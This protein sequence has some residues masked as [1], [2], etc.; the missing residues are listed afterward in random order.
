MKRSGFFKKRRLVELSVA[1]LIVCAVAVYFRHQTPV[2]Q[3]EPELSET[4]VAFT[5][6][7]MENAVE[8]MRRPFDPQHFQES[9]LKGQ[10]FACDRLLKEK[11]DDVNLLYERGGVHYQMGNVEAAVDDLSRI[12]E[13]QPD[14][15]EVRLRRA[16]LRHE[17]GS[18]YAAVA[19][20]DKIV[21]D[22]PDCLP[23]VYNSRA[24]Y[25]AKLGEFEEALPDIL[26]AVK[27]EPNPNSLDTLGYVY[28]GLSRY[29]EAIE[30]YSRG[31]ELN[32]D[33]PDMLYGRAAAY[34]HLGEASLSQ[35]DMDH[36]RTV[37]PDFCLHWSSDPDP[38]DHVDGDKS[39]FEELNSEG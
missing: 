19:D 16:Y 31:L 35:A 12:L 20:L 13:L 21:A 2:E 6:L 37:A 25:R 24:S 10:L 5:K 33:F 23:E 34:H 38:G 18:T 11:P 15:V 29:S 17:L 30:A 39:V 3:P 27:D 9:Q 14:N 26:R 1:V 8:G 22:A 4:G 32:P 36:L 28:M 7:L